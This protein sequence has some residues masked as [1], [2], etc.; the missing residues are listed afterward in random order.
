MFLMELLE[1]LLK[2]WGLDYKILNQT[3]PWFCLGAF[4]SEGPGQDSFGKFPEEL[5]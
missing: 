5:C 2:N 4:L 1:M 3:F